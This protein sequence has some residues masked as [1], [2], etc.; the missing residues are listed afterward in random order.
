MLSES[1]LTAARS[2]CFPTLAAPRALALSACVL[3]FPL[4]VLAQSAAPTTNCGPLA[5]GYGPFDYRKFDVDVHSPPGNNLW[6]VEMA[7]FTPQVEALIRG[8][9]TNKIAGDIDYTLRAFPNHPRAL[10]SMMRLGERLKTDQPPGASTTVECYFVHGVEF[11]PD[12]IVMRILYASFLSKQGRKEEA[13]R[14]LQVARGLA[15][16]DGFAHY[17]LGLAYL[18]L[19]AYGDAVAEAHRA[20]ALGFPKTVLKEQLEAAGKWVEPAAAAAS[21]PGAAAA[22]APAAVSAASAASAD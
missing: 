5:K 20:Q 14:Q 2:A 9:T 11:R 17:N 12:D 10:I 4:G 3:L 7:H 18:Q 16:D 19:G 13:M 21:A 6:L 22:V 15:G 8:N 1:A